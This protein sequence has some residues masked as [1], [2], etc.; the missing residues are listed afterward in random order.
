MLYT[1]QNSAAG[2]SRYS[3]HNPRYRAFLNW[4]VVHIHDSAMTEEVDS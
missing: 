3:N 1:N 2:S 4:S